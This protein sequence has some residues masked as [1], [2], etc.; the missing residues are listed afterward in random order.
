MLKGSS[1][2]RTAR[3]KRNSRAVRNKTGRKKTAGVKAPAPVTAA[4]PAPRVEAAPAASQEAKKR[5]YVHRNVI[6]LMRAIFRKHNPVDIAGGL[7]REG[8]DA[9]KARIFIQCLEYLYGKPVQQIETRAADDDAAPFQFFTHIPPPEYPARSAMHTNSSG[10]PPAAT[11]FA[12]RTEESDTTE[13]HTN[14]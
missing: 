6:K 1:A 9:T 2:P 3:A 14:E 10:T 12:G 4:A 8:T 5:G 7:L 11:A 13:E